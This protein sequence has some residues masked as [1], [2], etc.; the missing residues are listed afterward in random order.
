MQIHF[1]T[2]LSQITLLIFSASQLLNT[3]CNVIGR[4]EIC[5]SPGCITAGTVDLYT[6]LH[7]TVCITYCNILL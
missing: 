2:Y 6:I 7:T 3:N 5:V 1:A 4:K